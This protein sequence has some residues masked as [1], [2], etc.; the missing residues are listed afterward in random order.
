MVHLQLESPKSKHRNSSYV[1][2]N[3]DYSMIKT[4]A[5]IFLEHSP[6]LSEFLGHIESEFEGSYFRVFYSP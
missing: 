2:N 5:K 1:L 4:E 6:S 3:P